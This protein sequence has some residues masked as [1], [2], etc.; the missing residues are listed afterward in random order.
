M[1]SKDQNPFSEKLRAIAA[2]Q[3]K[4]QELALDRNS[5]KIANV[6]L[7]KHHLTP[8]NLHLKGGSNLLSRLGGRQPSKADGPR[9]DLRSEDG[10]R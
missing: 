6:L 8:Q 3:Q 7:G 4:P 2:S 1:N 9:R 5:H 10:R